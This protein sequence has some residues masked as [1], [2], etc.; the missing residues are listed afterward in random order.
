MENYLSPDDA[1]S[2]LRKKGYATD[3][4]FET[5]PFGLYSG[6]LDMRLNPEAYHVDESFRIDDPSHPNESETV[7]AISTASGVKGTVMDMHDE[8]AISMLESL[9]GI[10]GKFNVPVDQYLRQ[11]G[12]PMMTNPFQS[13]ASSIKIS[14]PISENERSALISSFPIIEFADWTVVQNAS[15]LWD[16]LYTNVIKPLKKRDFRFIFHLGDVA[17]KLVY[18]ID[19]VLDIIGDYSSYG[20]VTLMLDH[21]EAGHLWDKLNGSPNADTPGASGD[22]SLQAREKYRFIFDMMR[23]DS[24]VILD[25]YN[26]V[27][28]SRDGQILLPG[29]QAGISDVTNPR[30]RFS[31]GYQ[32][33]L[34]LQLE[35]WHCMALG[36]AVWQA[37]ATPV[38]AALSPGLN[39]PQLLAF[40]HDWISVL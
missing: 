26:V 12:E 4:G 9:A 32:M 34:L 20:K 11:I 24:L 8:G 23:I 17:N 21:G 5:N 16:G 15:G 2:D 37:G 31:A 39:S 10:I 19:E 35:T 36:L 38:E 7:Y 28:L 29:P 14:G 13:N 30:A 18:D 22:G 40:I 27:Q 33:G 6:D 1:L 3:L 25:G